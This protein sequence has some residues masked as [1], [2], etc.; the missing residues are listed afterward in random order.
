MASSADN[1]AKC[2]LKSMP[3]EVQ[4]MIFDY[5]LNAKYQEKMFL[6]WHHGEPGQKPDY[7]FGCHEPPMEQEFNTSHLLRLNKE[8][9]RTA[10]AQF[11]RTNLLVRIELDWDFSYALRSVIPC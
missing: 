7:D 4:H 6:N 5:L 10:I 9:S 8:I 2:Y 11:Y 1:Q 3:P